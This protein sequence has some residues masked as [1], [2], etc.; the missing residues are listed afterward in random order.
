M[1]ILTTIL[2][3]LGALLV[4]SLLVVIHELG[5]YGVGRLLGF[6]IVEFAVGMGPKL[7]KFEKNGIIYSLRAFPIGGM[8]Q[9]Y[10][11][12][13]AAENDDCFNSKPAWKRMLVVLAGPVMNILFAVILSI[14]TLTAFGDYM[15]QIQGFVEDVPSVA[16]QA[17]IEEGDFILA[18][19]GRS[20][21]YYNDVSNV[22]A[23]ADGEEAVFTVERNG[24][25][26]DITVKNLY[27]AELER[28]YMGVTIAAAR[29]SYSFPEACAGSFRYTFT[30]VREMFSFF[31]TLFKGQI[32]S[33][34]VMGFVGTIDLIGQAVRLGF[35]TVL[36]IA[37]LIS[38]NLGIVNL[39]PFPALDG[40]RL[41]F[42]LFA[43]FGIR[44]NERVE[45]IIHAVGLIILL[46]LMVLLTFGD[47]SRL[48]GG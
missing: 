44:I 1:S 7:F 24:E 15:P 18:I 32:H 5:H 36:R 21:A 10:G 35:E 3:I 4:I 17:G 42:L 34:D 41:V 12:D 30:M 14:I 48:I 13:N 29:K 9:F 26:L 31:G 46:G 25:K 43:I 23:A 6:K 19:D 33:G 20:I 37:V 8:C 39:L 28:N 16:Q 38:I 45:G 22:I 2:S 47:V 27:N 40:G 11:E